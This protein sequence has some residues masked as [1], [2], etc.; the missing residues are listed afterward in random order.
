MLTLLLKRFWPLIVMALLLVAVLIWTNNLKDTS[1][2]EGA[3]TERNRTTEGVLTNVQ[4]AKEAEGTFINPVTGAS[5]KYSQCVRSSRTPQNC[6]RFLPIGQ[7][8]IREPG[9]R[10]VNP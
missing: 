8:H 10:P 9:E 3:T 6:K 1:R 2:K 7:T 5:A 4:K